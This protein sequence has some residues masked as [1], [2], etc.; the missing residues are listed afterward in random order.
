MITFTI[1]R[2][3]FLFTLSFP[4]CLFVM[5][6][7]YDVDKEVTGW[8]TLEGKK[9]KGKILEIRNDVNTKRF[10]VLFKIITGKNL[11]IHKN[12]TS[13]LSFCKWKILFNELTFLSSMISFLCILY[14]C[15]QSIVFNKI[16]L[17]TYFQHKLSH[18]H[19]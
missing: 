12:Y 8:Q 17:S 2:S 1:C 13:Q 15:K 4:F 5:S 6:W 10:Y 16:K 9:E 19:K 3:N 18:T 14:S 11:F 7:M